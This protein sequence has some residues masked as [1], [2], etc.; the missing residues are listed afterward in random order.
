[1]K[2]GEFV[3]KISETD[4]ETADLI[5]YLLTL[6]EEQKEK[7]KPYLENRNSVEELKNSILLFKKGVE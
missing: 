3:K 7:I 5:I 1:M 4:T 6:D 2:E